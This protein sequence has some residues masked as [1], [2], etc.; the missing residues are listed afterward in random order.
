MAI[1]GTP[2]PSGTLASVEAAPSSGARPT[3]RVIA[4]AC[5]TSGASAASSPP[6]RSPITSTRSVSGG[7]PGA[8]VA[9]SSSAAACTARRMDCS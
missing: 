2:R 5:A 3:S 4:S 7:V 1:A 9:F 6:G 8:R